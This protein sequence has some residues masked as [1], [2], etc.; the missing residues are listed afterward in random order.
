MKWYYYLHKNG[1]LIGKNPVV[2]ES[3]SAAGY[4]NLPFVECAWRIDTE[5]RAD[6]W[7]M[8]L[9]ALARGAKV[10]RIKELAKQWDLNQTDVKEFLSRN[11]KELTDDQK[12]GLHKFIKEILII[13]PD[14]FWESLSMGN[15]K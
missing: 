9:K 6:V 11:N 7:R 3:D 10:D 4:F 14:V 8:V 2:V 1:D 5:N 13:E 15:S 12:Y